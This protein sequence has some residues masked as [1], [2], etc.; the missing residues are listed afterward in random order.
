MPAVSLPHIGCEPIANKCAG[1]ASIA[2]TIWVLVLPISVMIAPGLHNVANCPIC[3]ISNRTGVHRITMSASRTPSAKSVVATSTMPRSN[4]L[5]RVSS[6]REIPI[7]W[8]SSPAARSAIANDAP[9]KPTPTMQITPP[10]PYRAAPA[11]LQPDA[12]TLAPF[13]PSRCMHPSHFCHIPTAVQ[14]ECPVD[15]RSD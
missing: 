11:L 7:R 9:I 10:P 1:S 5:R 15:R 6:L 12:P 8:L 13:H 4:A 2:C 14:A 3:S